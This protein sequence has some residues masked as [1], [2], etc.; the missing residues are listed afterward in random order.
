MG[1][2]TLS[3]PTKTIEAAP[4]YTLRTGEALA[5]RAGFDAYEIVA[6]ERPA[7]VFVLGGESALALTW[8]YQR[9]TRLPIAA[10]PIARDWLR[11]RELLAFTEAL[12]DT[13]L[14]PAIAELADHPS[15]FVR[16]AA[17][18]AAARLDTAGAPALLRTLARDP[19][20]QVRLAAQHTLARSAAR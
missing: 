20:P 9:D 5:L 2:S 18:A 4:D 8:T 3:G 15:H 13:S 19:H 14:V 17:G 1:R 16:W 10:Q 12:G 6:H 11:V 7:I